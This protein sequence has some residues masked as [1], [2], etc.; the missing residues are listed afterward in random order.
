MKIDEDLE[1]L[2]FW[3]WQVL[4]LISKSTRT[5]S[6]NL[7]ACSEKK[8]PEFQVSEIIVSDFFFQIHPQSSIFV[9]AK[10]QFIR[11]STTTNL[12]IVDSGNGYRMS[13][14]RSKGEGEFESANGQTRPAIRS[15][16]HHENTLIPITENVYYYH[17]SEIL[18]SWA[19]PQWR[20]FS[21]I[22]SWRF[23]QYPKLL[24]LFFH[25]LLRI[26]LVLFFLGLNLLWRR[27]SHSF[28]CLGASEFRNSAP[29]V[30][31][32]KSLSSAWKTW[33]FRYRIKNKRFL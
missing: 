5:F 13:D 31:V 8:N 20:K 15:S 30:V 6:L 2:S 1:F 33:D 32:S 10:K 11:K 25:V 26:V 7:R 18:M 14:A 19:K 29:S 27:N 24:S 12:S 4:T 22:V 3:L 21:T 17:F 9:F 23:E 28:C 16:R